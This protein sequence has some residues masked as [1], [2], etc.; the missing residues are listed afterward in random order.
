MNK[1]IIEGRL[2]GDVRFTAFDNGNAVA[3][4]SVATNESWIDKKSGEKVESTEWHKCVVWNKRAEACAKI[5]KKGSRVL[6]EG[7]IKSRSYEAQPKD[8]THGPIAFG[9]G[10]PAVI[11]YPVTEIKV[12][13]ITFLDKKPT[14]DGYAANGQAVAAQAAGSPAAVAATFV[15]TTDEAPVVPPADDTSEAVPTVVAKPPVGV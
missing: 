2:G 12:Q 1:V 6:I 11:D 13:D 8:K 4:F 7:Q 9:D 10:T 3:N 5:L 14:T 15:G